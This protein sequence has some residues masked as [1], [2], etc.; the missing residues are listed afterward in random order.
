[1]NIF[2]SSNTRNCST[3][4]INNQIIIIPQTLVASIDVMPDL[5]H[6]GLKLHGVYPVK[7]SPILEE[8]MKGN[9][10]LNLLQQKQSVLWNETPGSKKKWKK[11]YSTD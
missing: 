3:L 8:K 5:S 9:L 7:K 10:S 6:L 4:I 1:M 2:F 11:W